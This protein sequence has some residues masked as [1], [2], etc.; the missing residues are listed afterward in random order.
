MA[1]ATGVKVRGELPLRA[2]VGDLIRLK[3][4]WR[5]RFVDACARAG[6]VNFDPDQVH[7][8]TRADPFN[9]GGGRR[10]FVQ[11]APYAFSDQQVTLAWPGGPQCAER[12]KEIRAKG[13]RP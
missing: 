10:L 1:S 9:P 2:Q 13:W 6:Y 3:E 7:V 4:D 12:E 11:D 5:A 8:V